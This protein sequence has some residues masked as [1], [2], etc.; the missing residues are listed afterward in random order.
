MREIEYETTALFILKLNQRVRNLLPRYNILYNAIQEDI[1]PFITYRKSRDRGL[2]EKVDKDENGS[3]NSNTTSNNKRVFEDTPQNKLLNVDYATDITN[4]D[5]NNNTDNKYTS[6]QD[7]N[8]SLSEGIV[9]E[10][11]NKPKIE[12]LSELFEKLDDLIIKM[13][14]DVGEPLFLK[15]FN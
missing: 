6:E 8:R 1:E 4:T 12:L 11:F 7:T 9:E 14:K 10:G 5:A 13:V 15:V 2:N 3:S